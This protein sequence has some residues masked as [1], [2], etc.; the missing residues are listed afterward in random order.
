MSVLRF[1]NPVSANRPYPSRT[2]LSSQLCGVSRILNS[3]SVRRHFLPTPIWPTC[4]GDKT[5][6]QTSQAIKSYERSADRTIC[7]IGEAAGVVVDRRKKKPVFASAHDLRRSFGERWASRL[8]PP[9]QMELMRHEDIQT[10]MRYYVDQNARKTAAILREAYEADPPRRGYH[11]GY[12]RLS[13][14]KKPKGV[15]G[16]RTHDGGF[17]IR[18]LSHLATTPG[19]NYS[20]SLSDYDWAVKRTW[21][22]KC[23]VFP[24]ENDMRMPRRSKS[25]ISGRIGLPINSELCAGK[26]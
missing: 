22:S 15:G 26:L 2:L 14:V 19:L 21:I 4:C 20:L 3:I 8:M 10:T 25:G 13:K 16:S 12:H 6:S 7:E 5:E 1:R 9:Q 24:N 18:C 23:P 17:A 11:F